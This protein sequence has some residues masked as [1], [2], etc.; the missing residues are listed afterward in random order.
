MGKLTARRGRRRRQRLRND[1]REPR[2][3]P[4]N[5]E[6]AASVPSRCPLPLLCTLGKPLVDFVFEPADAIRPNP[7]PLGKPPCPLFTIN[8]RPRPRDAL[9][10]GQ[11]SEPHDP[12]PCSHVLPCANI[13]IHILTYIC[14][15]VNRGIAG[16]PE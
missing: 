12:H 8:V 5:A 10:L 7:D 9:P 15:V 11:L 4:A 14:F 1:L 6:A 16:I 13:M 2:G 3:G